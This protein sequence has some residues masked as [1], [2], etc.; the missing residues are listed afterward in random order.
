MTRIICVLFSIFLLLPKSFAET[1][2]AGLSNIGF[3]AFNLTAP[4]FNCSGF[5]NAIAELET[6]HIAFLYNTFGNDFSC[7]IKI[8]KDP[9]LET[10][11]VHLINEPGHRNRRLGSYEFL[12]GVGS[13][14]RYDRLVK[15]K[16]AALKRKFIKYVSPLQKV[17]SANL[18]PHTSLFVNP[19]LESNLSDRSGKVL[20]SWTRSMFSDARVVWN[21][22]LPKPKRRANTRADI[23]EGH[24][25]SPNIN[26]PCIYNLDGTDVSYPGL[27]ALGEKEHKEGESKNWVQSGRPLHQLLETF[28]NECE[29]AYIWTAESNGLDR[30]ETRFVDPRKR[31]HNISESIYKIIM[32]DILSLNK[33]G[34][35]YPQRFDYTP[36]DN[37]VVKSCDI[38]K[39]SF[40]DGAKRGRLLKQS[41]FRNRGGVI[42]L[43]NEYP[44]V[45]KIH[46]IKGKKIIDV[47]VYD[48]KYKDGR[49]L[50]RSKKSPTKYPFKTYLTFESKGKKICF[51]IPNPRIRLD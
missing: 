6:L 21:P 45:K 2:P 27:P 30:K 36:D 42:I 12:F 13:V 17:L 5:L 37:S 10:L 47:Y 16:N 24:N 38:I 41:E 1:P 34:E 29:V 19:G 32:K 40:A 23:I 26:E 50:F 25:L 35:I 43:N 3:A 28:A 31:N 15:S 9:R 39:N 7:L 14:S 49:Q 44:T 46:I 33:T 8:L 18:Q 20:I 4:T 51:K 48:G 11:E 22:L